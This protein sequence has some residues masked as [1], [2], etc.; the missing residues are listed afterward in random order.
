MI[1]VSRRFEQS[2]NE[3]LT[4]RAAA[5]GVVGGVTGVAA[6][7][8]SIVLA[9]PG[10]GEAAALGISTLAA[11]LLGLA[12][13]AIIFMGRVRPLVILGLFAAVAWHMVSNPLLGVPGGLL[14]LLSAVFAL[15]SLEEA[16]AS[17]PEAAS[18]LSS[19]AR[20]RADDNAVP[21]EAG[22]GRPSNRRG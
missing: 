9:P 16:P 6:G 13:A 14:L 1:N 19:R 2:T 15:M 3:R 18:S 17:E 21:S 12:C 5:I 7:I 10:D 4:R 8:A 11:A 22:G 20:I